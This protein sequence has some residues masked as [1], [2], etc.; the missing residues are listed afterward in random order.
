FSI[1]VTR[2]PAE[3]VRPQADGEGWFPWAHLGIA[4]GPGDER[5]ARALVPD[6]PEHRE[7]GQAEGKRLTAELRRPAL[8]RA[9]TAPCRAVLVAPYL[10]AMLG[11]GRGEVNHFSYF[12][13]CGCAQVSRATSKR[14]KATL[15]PRHRRGTSGRSAPESPRI[16]CGA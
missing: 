11:S 12:S 14:P 10:C 8:S 6:S 2:C 1:C 4:P 3:R 9:R 5:P 15:N 13:G 7:G 16:V